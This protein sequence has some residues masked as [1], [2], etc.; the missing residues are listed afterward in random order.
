MHAKFG[1]RRE[2]ARGAPN[3]K[4]HIPAAD[5]SANVISDLPRKWMN[6]ME[7][8]SYCSS[9]PEVQQTVLG[10]ILCRLPIYFR[11]R[12]V[13]ILQIGPSR[14][15][16]CARRFVQVAAADAA[17]PDGRRRHHGRRC[18]RAALAL[19]SSMGRGKIPTDRD[20]A[21]P[22]RPAARLPA[23]LAVLRRPRARASPP[24]PPLP[25]HGPHVGSFVMA[26]AKSVLG[27][28]RN[29]SLNSWGGAL[30]HVPED[31]RWPYHM[32]ASAFVGGCGLHAWE[33]VRAVCP[34]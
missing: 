16:S 1:R 5:S 17:L 15:T 20:A 34:D 13:Y 3:R 4:N 32:F 25:E 10:P 21:A 31:R 2:H 19:H 7:V 26:P 30:V 33:T 24:P 8:F 22:P 9:K 14:V 6:T 18:A 27:A 12:P 23:A 28:Y 29:D 11:H